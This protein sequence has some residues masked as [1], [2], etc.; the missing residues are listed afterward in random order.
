[1]LNVY[2]IWQQH[3]FDIQWCYDN[4]IQ[5]RALKQARDV[6]KQLMQILDR[7]KLPLVSCGSLNQ[8]D[9][10]KI[11]KA[12]CAGFFYHAA[13]KDPTEGYKTLSDN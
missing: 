11:R 4:F 9:Y 3:G 2:E 8:K 7:F 6:R 1:M 13:K 12:I 10:N 5:A